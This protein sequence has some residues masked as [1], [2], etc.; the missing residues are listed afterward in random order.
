MLWFVQTRYFFIHLPTLSLHTQ[1][2]YYP[3]FLHEPRFFIKCLCGFNS[4]LHIRREAMLI[5][6]IE[7]AA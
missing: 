5:T 6:Q 7:T 4:A 1:I 2:Q 3:L